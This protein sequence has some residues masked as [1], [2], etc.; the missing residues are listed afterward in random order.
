MINARVR[1]PTPLNEPILGYAPGSAEKAALKDQLQRFA[2]DTLDIPL[3]IG[4]REVRTGDTGT[5]ILPHDHAT[6]LAA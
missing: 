6:V 1:V 4:G 3:V 5:C 2:K